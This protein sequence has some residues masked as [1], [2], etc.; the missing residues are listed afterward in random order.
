M[1]GL[2][3]AVVGAGIGGLTASLALARRGHAVTLVER[4]TGFSEVGAGL[5]LSPNASRILIGLGLGAALRRVATEP[6]RVVVR[7]IGSGKAIGQV[8]LGAFLR[9][10]FGAPYWVVH[11][12]DLQTVLLDAVRSEPGIRLVMGR[13][14]ETVEDGP[15]GARLA[16]VSAGGARE[17]LAVDLIVGADGIWSTIRPALGDTTPPAFRG[18]VAWRATFERSAAPAELSG[19]E[20][21]LWL[22]PKGH[23]VHYPIAGGRLVN[24]VAIERSAAPVEGWAAPGS[25]EALLKAYASAAPALRALLAQPQD[26]LRWS[27][28]DHPAGRLAGGRIALLGDAGHPVLPFLAQGAALA[29]EDAA[30]LAVLLGGERPDI[31]RALAAYETQRRPRAGRVQ[32][33][34]RRNGRIYHAGGLIGFGRNQVMRRLGPEG[35]TRRYDWLYGFRTPE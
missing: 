33:E 25:R 24:V 26:W 28:F 12:A 34:A 13:S 22:G 27:L 20:T 29:I 2:S 16:W 3:I 4:R 7:A 21:G 30:T 19:D 5:Q 15:D 17:S 9:E 31:P 11:R 14:V 18:A 1:S 8:A 10:R 6:Q 32:A 23:V 35:M